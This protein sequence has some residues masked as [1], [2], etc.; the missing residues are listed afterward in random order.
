MRPSAPVESEIE[1]RAAAGGRAAGRAARDGLP[2]AG[3]PPGVSPGVPPGVPPG[4][5]PGVSPGVPPGVSSGVSG[6]SLYAGEEGGSA[7]DGSDGT[8]SLPRALRESGGT[9]G[10]AAAAAAA[11]AGGG[12]ES[13]SARCSGVRLG[14]A[15]L[16]ARGGE[17]RLR[18]R[19]RLTGAALP[20][21]AAAVTAAWACTT[22]RPEGV[23]AAPVSIASTCSC[24]ADLRLTVAGGVVGE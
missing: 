19:V 22:V 4:V 23:A 3:D 21:V 11:A 10:S 9:T 18:L 24:T 17:A 7:G 20:S 8:G 12:G 2:A 13:G 6:S 5:S 16:A 15:A 1:R 14:L